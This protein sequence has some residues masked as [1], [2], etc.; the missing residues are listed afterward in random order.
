MGDK[1]VENLSNI[2]SIQ[3]GYFKYGVC[4]VCKDILSLPLCKGSDHYS[5]LVWE[6][7]KLKIKDIKF[8]FS[9]QSVYNELKPKKKF[10]FNII[11]RT[12]KVVPKLSDIDKAIELGLFKE[13]VEMV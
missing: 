3:E 8:C 6:I 11:K 13:R 5:K 1:I 9:C 4:E 7:Y 10:N 2:A 12:N